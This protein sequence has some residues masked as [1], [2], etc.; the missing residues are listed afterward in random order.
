MPLN[1]AGRMCDP[2]AC[3]PKAKWTWKSPT[4]APDP[5]DDPPGVCA[6][7]RGLSVAVGSDDANAVV[8]VLPIMLAPAPFS[9]ITT[10]AS[11][12]ERW[13]L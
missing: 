4:A 9:A 5:D 7:L 8:V 10:A 3:V 6:V 1:D 13:P 12:R 2:P 11:P